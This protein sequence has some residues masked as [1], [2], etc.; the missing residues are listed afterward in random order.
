[1]KKAYYKNQVI[2]D[3]QDILLDDFHSIHITNATDCVVMLNG[4]RF[5]DKGETWK[6]ENSNDTVIVSPLNIRFYPTTPTQKKK[7]LIEK[8][9]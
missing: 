5:I 7:V 2:T 6:W 1:M 4:N 8:F 3:N 9:Y